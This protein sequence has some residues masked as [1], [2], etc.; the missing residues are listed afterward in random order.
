MAAAR[1]AVGAASDPR[2]D[3]GADGAAG[4]GSQGTDRPRTHF[5]LLHRTPPCRHR[6]LSV[7]LVCESPDVSFVELCFNHMT[8]RGDLSAL[9]RRVVWGTEHAVTFRH[10]MI[11]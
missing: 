9:H 10:R 7:P 3:S 11:D 8:V 1:A 2:H 6:R 4:D 5:P